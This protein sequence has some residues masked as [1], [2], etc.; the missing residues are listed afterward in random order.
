MGNILPLLC[1]IGILWAFHVILRLQ[2]SGAKGMLEEWA[3]TNG[4]QILDRSLNFTRMPKRHFS[5]EHSKYSVVYCVALLDQNHQRKNAWVLCDVRL[6][7]PHAEVQ[8]DDW[9]D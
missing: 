5:L 6:L 9:T 4:Y 8:W 2:H 3:A 7:R 1:L